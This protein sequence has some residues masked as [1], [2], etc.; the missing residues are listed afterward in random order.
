[1][2]I[3]LVSAVAF[4]FLF[5]ASVCDLKNGEIPY[6]I[7]LGFASVMFILAAILFLN[8]GNSGLIL[9]P[10]A[11]GVGYFAV[12]YF[13][14]KL[15]QW[16]GG[17][18]KLLLG[19]GLTFGLL[20]ALN[21]QWNTP[22]VPYYIVYFIDLGLLAMPYALLYMIVLSV[23][24]PAVYLKFLSNLKSKSIIASILLGALA[25]LLLSIYTGLDFFLLFSLI[26]PLFV[27]LSVFLR[28]SEEE[29]MSKTVSV[30]QL[31]EA[32]SLAQDLVYKG[33]K[34]ASKRDIEGLTLE[35]VALIKKLAAQSKVPSKIKI[36]WGVR[37]APMLF[38]AFLLTAYAGDLLYAVIKLALGLQA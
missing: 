14:F 5:L 35:Q 30:K 3:L 10:I 9:N 32:D 18:V 20:N 1:M 12:A 36:R 23:R 25:P 26:L 11:I 21:F 22:L 2:S 17:D 8:S 24:K 6:K 15:G 33:R 37:F 28:T 31:K 7:T 13:L 16:G 34:I 19:V 38:L 29:L 4:F 27:L